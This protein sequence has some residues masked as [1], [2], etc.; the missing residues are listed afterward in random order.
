[1]NMCLLKNFQVPDDRIA[2]LSD[3]LLPSVTIKPNVGLGCDNRDMYMMTSDQSIKKLCC[4]FCKKLCIKL[5]RHME[6]MHS[7]ETDVK[8]FMECPKG[9]C[10]TY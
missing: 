9:I 3:S 6:V 8:K 1:M 10:C 4:P 2:N 7:Q 5:A